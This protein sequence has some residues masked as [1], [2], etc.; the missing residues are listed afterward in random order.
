M[1]NRETIA[2]EHRDHSRRE[3]AKAR[4]VARRRSRRDKRTSYALAMA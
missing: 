4:A 2:R 3:A 1:R